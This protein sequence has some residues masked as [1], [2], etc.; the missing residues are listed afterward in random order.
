MRNCG[1]ELCIVIK[2][3]HINAFAAIHFP[4]NA[5]VLVFASIGSYIH[6]LSSVTIA[7]ECSLIQ[8]FS[9]TLLLRSLMLHASLALATTQWTNRRSWCALPANRYCNVR[10]CE[11]DMFWWIQTRFYYHSLNANNMHATCECDVRHAMR[12]HVDRHA[13]QVRHA[14]SDEQH[15]ACN[16]ERT[17][18]SFCITIG[19]ACLTSVG[20]NAVHKIAEAWQLR[21]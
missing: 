12:L 6:T 19:V 5:S 11:Y 14:T 8:F 13:M 17:C 18:T 9:V 16:H 2:H 1:S 21:G 10:A 4:W 7:I 3:A 15:E 20:A